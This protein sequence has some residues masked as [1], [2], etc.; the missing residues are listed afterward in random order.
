MDGKGHKMSKSLGNVIAPQEIIQKYGA[1]ILRL[2]V[3]MSDYR[4]DVRLSQDI[5]NHVI[6][7]YR[8][9]RNTFRFLLQNT[10]DFH[11]E[12]NRCDID[13]LEEIDRWILVHFEEV[14]KRVLQAYEAHEF[15]V[16]L[17]ELNRFAAVPLSGFYLDALKDRLYCE[18]VDS[19]KRRSAQTAFCILA[20]GLFVLLAPLVSFTAEEAYLDLRKASIPSLPESVFL[21]EV[22]HLSPVS[23][24]TK[25]NDKWLKILD[26]RSHV[27]DV[28][29]QVRKEGGVRSSQE[30]HLHL[31]PEKLDET[32][33]DLLK[34][35]DE[36][37]SFIFQMSE[38]HIN[39][40]SAVT[41]AIVIEPTKNLKC[42][43]CWRHRDDVGQ[44][45]E[46]PTLCGRCVDVVARRS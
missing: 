1:D 25:L 42:E 41:E 46:H 18:A 28:L 38:V 40:K 44:H 10:S 5:L 6:D 4:D 7:L 34:A 35:V 9:F 3:A 14:K 32:K 13:K 15:H 22:G 11:W 43:R 45:K 8:R 17:S 21:D 31:N 23:F 27:N 12:K 2:W 37:W 20:R 39:G 24:D 33:K 26:L 19:P 36:D 29:D 30:A 16:V